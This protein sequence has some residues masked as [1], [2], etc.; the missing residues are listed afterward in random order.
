M[1]VSYT[2]EEVRELVEAHRDGESLED[3]EER[4]AAQFI[5]QCQNEGVNPAE[6][7]RKAV[8]SLRG[9]NRD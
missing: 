8:S 2:N 1:N 7:I 5:Q 4:L 9:T 6:A 3:I